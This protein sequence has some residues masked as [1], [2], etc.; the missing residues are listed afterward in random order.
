[1]GEDMK[2]GFKYLGVMMALLLAGCGGGGDDVSLP[3]AAELCGSV[4]VQPKIANGS[5]C[6][7]PEKRR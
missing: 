5:N 6:A 7:S 4:G 1:M 3:S 2:H